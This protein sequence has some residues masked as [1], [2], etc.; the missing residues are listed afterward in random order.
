[1]DLKLLKTFVTTV[2]TGNFRVAAEKLFI[3]QPSITVHIK[4]L[5][6]YLDVQLFD[7]NHTKVQLTEEGKHFYKS[8]IHIL[9][10]VTDSKRQVKLLNQQRVKQLHIR[11]SAAMV[12]THLPHILYK[13]SV[14]FPNYELNIVVDDSE[15][16]N[17]QLENEQLLV[18]F[19]FQKAV[20]ASCH[21]ERVGQ[22]DFQFIYPRQFHTK[23]KGAYLVIQ[24]LI[25]QYPL[26]IGHLGAT[27][28]LEKMFGELYPS[29]RKL[30]IE[31]SYYIKQFVKA[32]LGMAFLPRFL[33]AEELKTQQIQS[34]LFDLY[35]L[36]TIEMYMCYK[37]GDEE[38]LPFLQFV[39]EHSP[40][41]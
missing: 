28:S 32:G 37:K 18:T 8:A 9:N 6:E 14:Q 7:R 23:N 27:A 39:R 4:Q 13:F 5:E 34:L 1:M 10:V 35:Y 36:P 11:L 24:E 25:D 29:V 16:I 30:H 31:Q 17:H 15:N 40:I 21:S 38:L 19:S 2:E 20:Q 26:M 33:I 3:S 41:V 22:S 12:E